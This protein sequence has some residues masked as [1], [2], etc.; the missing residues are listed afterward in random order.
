MSLFK[1]P[2]R[3]REFNFH[4][5]YYDER[6][7]RLQKKIDLYKGENKT[8]DRI[9]AI[10]FQSDLQDNWGKSHY[11]SQSFKSNIRLIIILVL[12]LAVF[13]YI[14]IGLDNVGTL[15]ESSK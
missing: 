4:P 2:S 15:L 6:K 1:M 11:K 14:F 13:Y 5:R 3:T 9:R 12:I 10:K 7:Q 8:E